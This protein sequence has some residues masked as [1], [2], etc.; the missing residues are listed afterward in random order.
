MRDRELKLARASLPKRVAVCGAW[1]CA[2]WGRSA[3]QELPNT[4][5][6]VH[7]GTTLEVGAASETVNVTSSAEVTGREGRGVE[8]Q[9]R[10]A[11]LFQL[12]APSANVFNL[13]R[14]VAGILPV[15]VEVPRSGKSYRFVRPLVLEEE[16]RISFQYKA[17]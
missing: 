13:Q 7:L 15:R 3:Q 8:N 1:T 5:K 2:R 9:A 4:G 12:T 17:K 6:P 10:K 11:Q 14:R 16:T